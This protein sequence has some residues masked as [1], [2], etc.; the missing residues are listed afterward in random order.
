MQEK[1]S[2]KDYRV[3]TVWCKEDE[4]ARWLQY[5][6][7][8]F[9]YRKRVLKMLQYHIGRYDIK[10]IIG[11]GKVFPKTCHVLVEIRVLG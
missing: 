7:D 6:T 2:E 5:A 1:R 11:E 8:L 9:E 10:G 4:L 3:S